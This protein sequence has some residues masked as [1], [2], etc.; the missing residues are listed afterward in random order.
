VVDMY[1]FSP[2]TVF[3]TGFFGWSFW[4]GICIRGNHPRGSVVKQP[5]VLWMGR[6]TRSP[7]PCPV[8]C[9]LLPKL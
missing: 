5:E 2:R 7:S 6:R 8:A 4:W 9:G 3:P 1:S